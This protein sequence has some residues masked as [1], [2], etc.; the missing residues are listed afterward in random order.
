MALHFP[1]A[2][3]EAWASQKSLLCVGL[4]PEPDRFP[5]HLKGRTDRIFEFCSQIVDATAP[6]VCAFKPQ[7]AYFS[8][9]RAEDQLEDLIKHIHTHHPKIPV[10]LDSKRGDIG[11]TAE[12]Y[13]Q[14]AFER[15][16]AD[17]VTLSPYM[18][19]DTLMPFLEHRDK[20][21]FLLCRTS[22]P[23]G[24]DFQM[25]TINDGK[26]LFEHVAQR[27][28]ERYNRYGNC[29]L[30]VGATYPQELARVRQI[31]GPE[32]PLLVPGIGAQGGDGAA[33]IKAAATPAGGLVI[34]SSRAVLYVGTDENFYSFARQAAQSARQNLKNF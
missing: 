23:G 8:A 31:V 9:A 2:L 18:G 29:G 27:A 32:M 34:N 4:D 16:G 24:D 15:F 20:G 11:S 19:E 17:A 14:E 6:F 21:I 26:R 22:N 10:I 13:A 3:R 25:L 5:T 1:T 12:K 7:I 33:V 28:A 30:V